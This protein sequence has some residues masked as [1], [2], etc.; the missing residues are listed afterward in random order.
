MTKE[1]FVKKLVEL[2]NEFEPKVGGEVFSV[3]FTPI[4]PAESHCKLKYSPS[5]AKDF[6]VEK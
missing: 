5:I 3:H 6:T 1:V 2:V 4:T